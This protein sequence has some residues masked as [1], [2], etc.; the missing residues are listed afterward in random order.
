MVNIINAVLKIIYIILVLWYVGFVASVIFIALLFFIFSPIMAFL[1]VQING[2]I[3]FII[4]YLI[5]LIYHQKKYYL[6]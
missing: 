5:C 4:V 2:N 1:D 3:A 6:F